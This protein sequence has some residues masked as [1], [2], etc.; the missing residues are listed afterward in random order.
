MVKYQ[1]VESAIRGGISM[2]C[3]C[4]ADVNNKFLKSEDVNKPTSYIVY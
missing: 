3:K 1:F 2:T 4:Y